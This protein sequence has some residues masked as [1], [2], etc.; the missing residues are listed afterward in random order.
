MLDEQEPQGSSSR[1]PT[2]A[3]DGNMSCQSQTSPG[4]SPRPSTAAS[5]SYMSFQ[6]QTSFQSQIPFS[7]PASVTE[8]EDSNGGGGPLADPADHQ[9][10]DQEGF[11]T[12]GTSNESGDLRRDSSHSQSIACPSLD[13]Q[14]GD[15]DMQSSECGSTSQHIEFRWHYSSTAE[16]SHP[17]VT[18]FVFGFSKTIFEIARQVSFCWPGRA[19][20]RI[21]GILRD[22]G[23]PLPLLADSQ[24]VTYMDMA[25]QHNH[26]PTFAVQVFGHRDR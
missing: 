3:T 14:A 23:Q 25:T 18:R 4:S 12:A 11:E 22:G 7:N 21:E 15:D 8:S 16:V 10:P 20:G 2:P 17:I 9:E 6:S 19:C 1:Q 13:S 26:V 24:V 5:G